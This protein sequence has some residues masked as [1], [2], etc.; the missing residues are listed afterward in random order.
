MSLIS[1]FV[2]TAGLP[3]P[4]VSHQQNQTT[5]DKKKTRK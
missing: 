5:S 2:F 3:F 1:S 4:E